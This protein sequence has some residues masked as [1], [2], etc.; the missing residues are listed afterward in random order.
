MAIANAYFTT[1]PTPGHVHVYGQQA[2]PTSGHNNFLFDI[3]PASNS[4]VSSA[5]IDA[6]NLSSPPIPA[7]LPTVNI[8]LGHPITGVVVADL[9]CRHILVATGQVV[10]RAGS[11]RLRPSDG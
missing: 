4:T 10:L 6:G 5:F 11:G 2:A 9:T 8:P 7:N 3:D 1:G